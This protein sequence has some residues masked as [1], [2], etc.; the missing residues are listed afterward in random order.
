MPG[1]SWVLPGTSEGP[2]EPSEGPWS[3]EILPIETFK[4]KQNRGK[5]EFEAM[6]FVP[7]IYPWG[8]ICW[9]ARKHI[10]GLRFSNFL[11]SR[12]KRG[13]VHNS[14]LIRPLEELL[15]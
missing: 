2:W 1:R 7:R 8:L 12:S 15:H 5:S 6:L 13:H 10:G 3:L 14:A 11:G 9:S 4:I